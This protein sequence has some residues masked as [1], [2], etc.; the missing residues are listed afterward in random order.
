MG[1]R[2]GLRVVDMFCVTHAAA[3]AAVAP[4]VREPVSAFL[5]GAATHA[6]LDMIPHYDYDSTIPGVL[7][8]AVAALLIAS[9]GGDDGGTTVWAMLGGVLPDLEVVMSY[10]GLISPRD[11]VFPSHS[12][13]LPHRN[14]GLPLGVLT[15]M[16]V[17]GLA[18]LSLGFR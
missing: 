16:A 12:G 5:A 9:A 17:L 6:V 1:A 4:F 10:L 11:L 3:G 13:L 2:K 18:Y 14:V 8:F 15:Q 7:D